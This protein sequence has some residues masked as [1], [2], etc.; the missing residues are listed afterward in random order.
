[1]RWR[2]RIRSRTWRRFCRGW[3]IIS[4]KSPRSCGSASARW[5]TRSQSLEVITTNLRD[6]YLRRNG[7]PYSDKTKL[8]EY[9]DRWTNP[10]GQ[11]WFTVTTI[12]EDPVYLERPFVTTTDFRRESDDS[13]FSPTPCAAR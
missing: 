11:E 2:A 10:E 13:K 7:V 1:M 5:N 12:V 4:V 9:F 6:G 8:T 3:P